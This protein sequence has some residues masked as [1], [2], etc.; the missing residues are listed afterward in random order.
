MMQDLVVGSVLCAAR[1]DHGALRRRIL[2]WSGPCLL[3]AR[4]AVELGA[5]RARA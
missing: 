5:A 3:I 2:S 4:C 1:G